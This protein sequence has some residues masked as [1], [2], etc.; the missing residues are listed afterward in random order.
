MRRGRCRPHP[1]QAPTRGGLF[2]YR[3][4]SLEKSKD[5]CKTH[6]LH[7][8]RVRRRGNPPVVALFVAYMG[9]M[10]SSDSISAVFSSMAEMPQKLS[11]ES[12]MARS[13]FFRSSGLAV[14][15]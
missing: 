15:R 11:L 1:T 8:I 6:P 10:M 3:P 13:I 4:F 9:V 14:N 5:G 7:T 12:A 2:P